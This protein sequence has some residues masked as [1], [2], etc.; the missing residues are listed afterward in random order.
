MKIERLVV[1][2]NRLPVGRPTGRGGELELPAGGLVSSLLTALESIP[3][4]LWIGWDGRA[5]PGG[6][7]T[8]SRARGVTLAGLGLTRSEVSGYYDGF[9][10]QA[11][12]PLLHCLPGRLAFDAGHLETY[13]AV[14]ERFA[15]VV[16]PRIHRGDAV[17]VHD[18]HLLRLGD[19]LRRRGV[20]AR[21]GFFLHTPFPPDDIWA[22]L[23]R[24]RRFLDSLLSFDLVGFHTRRYLE[25]YV[26]ACRREIGADWDGERLALGRR[27]QRV[28]VYPV[29]IDPADFEPSP[30]VLRRKDRAGALGR[31]AASRRVVLGVD[32]LDYTKGLPE[33]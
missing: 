23:P 32:R 29:G 27:M 19:A 20:R 9:C 21:L 22:V 13:L 8:E 3:S 14:Q 24:S 17:W 33:R 5:E 25:N 7:L 1:I 26:Q 10:N 4:S 11:L 12:W 15:D 16:A 2:S 18:Y 28:G 30:A 6:R 31:L